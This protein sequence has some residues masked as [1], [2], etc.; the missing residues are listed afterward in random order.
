MK[1]INK[2]II[3][4]IFIFSTVIL[5]QGSASAAAINDTFHLNIQTTFSNGTIQTGTFDLT[6]NITESSSS[7][8]LGPTLYNHTFSSTTTDNRGILSLYLPTTGSGGGTLSSLSYTTQYY[9][10]YYR[11]GAIKDVSQLSRVPYSFGASQVNI[12]ELKIDSNLD[13]GTKNVT[14]SSGFFTSVGSAISRVTSLF[15]QDID[16]SGDVTVTGNM[17]ASWFKGI[18]NWIIGPGTSQNYLSFNGTDLT[19]DEA[20]L[21]TT[22]DSRAVTNNESLNNYIAE[23][24]ASVNNYIAAN[25]QSVNDYIIWVNSTNAGTTYSAT[26]NLTQTGN[27]FDLNGTS[28]WNWLVNLFT[29]EDYVNTQNTSMNN[30]LTSYVGTQNGSL[31]N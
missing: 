16:A 23:N 22:I 25:N 11:D 30:Y 28:V 1:G 6:F 29:T 19:F 3:L 15:T 13:L 9:L 4:G 12:S 10:C 31:V 18:F 14:A 8:C 20:Q 17:T 24:N 27:A 7:S 26:G 2:T 5:S 21:N